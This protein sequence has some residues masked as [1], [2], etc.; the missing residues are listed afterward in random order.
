[1]W[2]AQLRLSYGKQSKGQ[3]LF[4]ADQAR[5]DLQ[6]VIADLHLG[7]QAAASAR[8]DRGRLTDFGVLHAESDRFCVVK[9]RGRYIEPTIAVKNKSYDDSTFLFI[10]RHDIAYPPRPFISGGGPHVGGVSQTSPRSTSV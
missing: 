1:M 6:L 7:C 8:F 2:L 5:P 4:P 3:D 9:E 10:L